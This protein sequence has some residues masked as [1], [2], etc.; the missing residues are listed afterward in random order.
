[1]ETSGRAEVF[2]YTANLCVVGPVSVGKTSLIRRISLLTRGKQQEISSQ[3]SLMAEMS[4]VQFVVDN[5]LLNTVV[6]DTPGMKRLFHAL[7]A[8]ILRNQAGYLVVFDLTDRE[9]FRDIQDWFQPVREYSPKNC[10][11]FLVGNKSDDSALR[12]VDPAEAAA[13]A[14]RMNAQYF[15]TSSKT[16]ANVGSVFQK[17]VENIQLKAERGALN[18]YDLRSG[19]KINQSKYY[20]SSTLRR[21][22][23][24]GPAGVGRESLGCC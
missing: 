22:Q 15:E 11:V 7:P 13:L 5:K 18:K 2:D 17:L 16:G 24:A 14:A 20:A 3:P 10:E 6:T 9:T 1:M 4:N 21:P 19:L 8:N 12:Q 23:Q